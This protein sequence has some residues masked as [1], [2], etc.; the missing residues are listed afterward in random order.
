MKLK[1]P[2]TV[3]S[4]AGFCPGCGQPVI[5]DN[6]TCSRCGTLLP[7]TAKFCPRCGNKRS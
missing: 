2:E 1:A 7:P 5:Q 4:S 3:F 6:N